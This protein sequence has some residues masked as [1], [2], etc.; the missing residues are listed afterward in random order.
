M[1]IN[2]HELSNG[3]H[4]GPAELSWKAYWPM[5]LCFS[6]YVSR[7]D[8]IPR[9]WRQFPILFITPEIVFQIGISRIVLQYAVGCQLVLPHTFVIQVNWQV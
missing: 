9:N 2:F 8:H 6:K 5:E 3:N 1:D 7:N 4:I